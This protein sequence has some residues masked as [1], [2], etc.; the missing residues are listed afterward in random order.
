MCFRYENNVTADIGMM[1]TA[2]NL[3]PLSSAPEN[4]K[5]TERAI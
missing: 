2:M 3:T 4:T 5:S 1:N